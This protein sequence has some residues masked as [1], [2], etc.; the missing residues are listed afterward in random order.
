LPLSQYY[1][2]NWFYLRISAQILVDILINYGIIIP[3]HYSRT[4]GE[5][6]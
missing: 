2:S 4:L 5:N 6:S 1:L 3:R